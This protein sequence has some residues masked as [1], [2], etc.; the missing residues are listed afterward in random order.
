M[1][2]TVSKAR[3]EPDG[4][5]DSKPD[6]KPGAKQ[7]TIQFVTRTR[8]D[9]IA[10]FQTKDGSLIRELMHPA[11]HACNNLS[12]AEATV[13]P[14]Q[15]TAV[16]LHPRSEEIYYILSGIGLKRCSPKRIRPM[17]DRI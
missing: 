16:H 4:N 17:P 7:G 8:Y 3:G 5:P 1:S 14:G 2:K 11:Q 12:L 6:A 9:A 10:S 13:L 15:S